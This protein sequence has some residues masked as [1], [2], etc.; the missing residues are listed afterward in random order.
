MK[1]K[2]RFNVDALKLC[3]VAVNLDTNLYQ[4]LLDEAVNGRIERLDYSLNI[5]E[6]TDEHIRLN[7]ILNDQ[8]SL[9]W[10]IVTNTRT[11]SLNGKH[12]FTFD[13]LA[14]YTPFTSKE[15]N[16]LPLA[17]YVIEHE[18]LKVNN[19][20][21]IELALDSTSNLIQRLDKLVRNPQLK[22]LYN[23]KVVSMDDRLEGS[24][25]VFGR[26]RAK[27]DRQPS[28]YFKGCHTTVKAYNK[29]NEIEA[30][31]KEYIKEY[32]G[33]T[34]NKL[35]RLE[36]TLDREAWLDAIPEEEIPYNAENWLS[37]LLDETTRC[38]IWSNAMSRVIRFKYDRQEATLLQLL[39]I[40]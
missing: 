10:L 14:L 19:I 12:Y 22:M 18:G 7:I 28:L 3:L 27:R 34:A 29:Q 31:N 33:F 35:Y 11:D 26:T 13:N 25:Y 30:S 37:Y 38:I 24:F 5:T 20:T 36:V 16:L 2:T 8:T 17:D 6:H 4:S 21:S 39:E 40:L 23:N 15:T 1:S 9:G 32:D